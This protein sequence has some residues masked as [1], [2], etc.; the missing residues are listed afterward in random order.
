MPTDPDSSDEDDS[1]ELK[2]TSS[3]AAD[4]DDV[5]TTGLPP[6][7]GACRQ[8][9]DGNYNEHNDVTTCSKPVDAINDVSNDDTD[10]GDRCSLDPAIR[11]KLFQMLPELMSAANYQRLVDEGHV[12][13]QEQD[14]VNQSPSWSHQSDTSGNASMR[15]E[16]MPAKSSSSSDNDDSESSHVMRPRVAA[17]DKVDE[18]SS[19]TQVY[20]V[21]ACHICDFVCK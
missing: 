1:A 5:A 2:S 7:E 16:Q 17:D 21:F 14:D 8:D 15:A 10:A 6:V 3:A 4:A 11:R 18:S 19:S 20:A 13:Y 9:T 12:V